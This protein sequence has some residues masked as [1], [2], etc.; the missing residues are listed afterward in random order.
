M[1]NNTFT[2][3]KY[4][5]III[6]VGKDGVRWNGRSGQF[7]NLPG[8]FN[9]S[10]EFGMTDFA[11]TGVYGKYNGQFIPH[12][13]HDF[14]GPDD[15][16]SILAPT[17]VWIT[18]I[19]Y[20]KGG[21]GNFIFMETETIKMNGDHIKMV[22]VVAHMK[23][24]TAH[25]SRWYNMGDVLGEMGTTGNSTGTHTHFGG[26]P[27]IIVN[28][29]DKFMISEDKALR[30]YMDLSKFFIQEPIYNN[31]ELIKQQMK[32]VKKEGSSDL[33]AID[34]KGQTNLILNMDTFHLGIEMGLWDGT[35]DTVP[36][37]VDPNS[38]RVIIL[39]K[40]N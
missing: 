32:V 3:H 6:P 10:Q 2:L 25:K 24:I 35:Y 29:V 27:I 30:G 17:R 16:T 4:F 18:Y 37:I 15:G 21:Y 22:F 31:F 12:R 5:P 14:A 1:N 26:R 20:D 33:Y 40:N 39:T 13:G 23:K 8:K 7:S 11:K 19:G 38:G 34:P 9:Y 28:G 36:E